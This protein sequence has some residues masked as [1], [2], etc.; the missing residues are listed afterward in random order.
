[1]QSVH[2]PTTIELSQT[3]L[4]LR[5]DLE[6]TA[7]HSQGRSYWHISAQNSSDYFRIA[8]PEYVFLSCLDG[9]TS[10]CQA[11]ALTAR[12]LKADSIS[13]SDAARLYNWLLRQDFGSLC[14]AS[15][16]KKP[17]KESAARTGKPALRQLLNPFWMQVPLGSP[18]RLLRMLEPLGKI[19]FSTGFLCVAIC[20]FFTAGLQLAGFGDDF[21]Q[22]TRNV[23]SINN[24]LWLLIS[25]IL[26]KL[27]HETAHGLACLRYGGRVPSAGVAFVLFAPMAWIDASACWAFRSRWQRI[28][29]AGAGVYLEL[30]VAS[31]AV[32]LWPRVDHAVAQNLLWNIAFMASA[33]TILFNMNPFMR[34]DGYFMLSDLLGIPNL[35]ERA[36]SALRGVASTILIGHRSGCPQEL[37]WRRFFLPLFALGTYAWRIVVICT[38]MMTASVMLH[39][40]GIALAIAAGLLW[41]ARP[42][43]AML[44]GFTGLMR[45]NPVAAIRCGTISVATLLAVVMLANLTPMPM[46]V[47]APGIVQ[48]DEGQVVRTTTSGFVSEIHIKDGQPVHA[49]DPLISLTNDELSNRRFSLTKMLEMERIRLQIA[50]RNHDVKAEN[51]AESN[52]RSFMHQLA[53]VDREFEG[54]TLRAERSGTAMIRQPNLLKDTFVERGQHLLTVA[55][56]NSKQF[57]LAVA[58]ADLDEA[59][60]FLNCSVSVR[61][62]TRQIINGTFAETMPAASDRPSDAALVATNGGPLDV[63]ESPESR[64]RDG[65]GTTEYRLTEP[66]FRGIVRFPSSA[67][68]QIRCGERG[69]VKL[70]ISRDTIATWLTNRVQSWFRDTLAQLLQ[71]NA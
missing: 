50:R 55:D 26:L 37:G 62:G 31:V 4:K 24:W 20:L 63:V 17:R 58:E 18:E 59:S 41:Y 39:G 70:G 48:Y 46:T 6:V 36:S 30:V 23:F 35:N 71:Q 8:W 52:M 22:N 16:N 54:L 61:I 3:R 60:A 34:F 68:G 21:L 45:S 49:G 67:A 27:V 44:R 1:M 43:F 56:P 64:S 57:E 65:D 47:T 11:L 69:Y 19:L 29:T 9:E 5:D 33:S 13:E 51:V 53:E 15:D 12:T 25:W 42:L 40:A 10:F 38:L 32:L 2:D 7:H 28:V 14:D 66:R